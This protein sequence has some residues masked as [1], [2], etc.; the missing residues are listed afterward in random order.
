MN[1]PANPVTL[2]LAQYAPKHLLATVL[3][4]LLDASQLRVTRGLP[5]EILR[6]IEDDEPIAELG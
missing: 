4:T 1:I 5:R 6:I 3:H 2:P